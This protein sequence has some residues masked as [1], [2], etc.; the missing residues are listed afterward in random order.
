M[1]IHIVV[2]YMKVL[3]I[4]I[5]MNLGGYKNRTKNLEDVLKKSFGRKYLHMSEKYCTF[6]G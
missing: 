1:I 5:T 2:L 4:I 6:A 3:K